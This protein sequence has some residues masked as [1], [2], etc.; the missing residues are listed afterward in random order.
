MGNDAT[1]A[2]IGGFIAGVL[3]IA[4]FSFYLASSISLAHKP[5]K[6]SIVGIP[7][8]SS[9]ATSGLNFEPKTIR[10]VIGVNN[11]VEWINKDNVPHTPVLDR[12][13]ID[14]V[15]GNF[16]SLVQGQQVRGGYILPG[17]TF[18]FTF[19]QSGSYS[20]HGEPHPWMT[21]TVIVAQP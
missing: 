10:V 18:N 7:A 11:T 14:P 6:V 2:A 19:T 13:Y 12:D 16:S 5:P 17:Q 3:L 1:F 21:G 4:A 9:L 15:S 8:G 20:Y